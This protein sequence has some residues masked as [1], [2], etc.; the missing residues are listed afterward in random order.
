MAATASDDAQHSTDTDL[1]ETTRHTNDYVIA[2]AELF[3]LTY[4]YVFKP[5][6]VSGHTLDSFTVNEKT[7]N[8]TAAGNT[9]LPGERAAA[10]RA[11]HAVQHDEDVTFARDAIGHKIPVNLTSVTPD[12]FTNPATDNT[13]AT[14]A[15]NFTN[16][17]DKSGI[18]LTR[19][20]RIYDHYKDDHY[21]VG[22]IHERSRG[23]IARSAEFH[24][25]NTDDDPKRLNLSH[26][27]V[28]LARGSW[29]VI[30]SETTITS[31]PDYTDDGIDI[32][33]GDILTG[34]EDL[35]GLTE[36]STYRVD[37]I[38]ALTGMGVRVVLVP[39][40]NL[41]APP[42]AQNVRTYDLDTL[43]AANPSIN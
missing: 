29:E 19:G 23:A 11:F 35:D 30:D 10:E 22:I 40:T 33:V 12:E 38:N 24:R 26:V 42:S 28:K 27:D 16:L 43:T 39:E 18:T 20:D 4:R 25:L 21:E 41:N 3:D 34:L 32:T 17:R 31:I 5:R 8:Q 36:T 14:P 37:A 9:D 15:L 2:T 7:Y 13:D 6:G 1:V